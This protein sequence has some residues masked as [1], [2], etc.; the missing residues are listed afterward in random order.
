MNTDRVA[1]ASGAPQV[2]RLLVAGGWLLAGLV[3]EV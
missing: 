1:S 3:T 2:M